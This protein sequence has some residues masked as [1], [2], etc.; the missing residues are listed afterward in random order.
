MSDDIIGAIVTK[1]RLQQ[2]LPPK[3]ADPAALRV[4]ARLLAPTGG[5]S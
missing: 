3:V 1:Q 4:I 5:S 2:G